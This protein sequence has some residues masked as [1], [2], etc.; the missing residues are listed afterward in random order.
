MSFAETQRIV[1]LAVLNNAAWC[2]SMWR[3]CGLQVEKPQGMVVCIGQ[4]PQFYPN[5]MTL[6]AD[7]DPVLQAQIIADL[8]KMA[9]GGQVSVKDSYARLDLAPLGFRKLFEAQWIHCPPGAKMPLQLDWRL[10]ETAADLQD[11]ESV[12]GGGSGVGSAVFPVALLADTSV[13]VFGG[14]QAGK[15]VAGAILSPTAPV[16][17]VSNVFGDYAEVTGLVASVFPGYGIVGYEHG[18]DLV[19]AMTAGFEPKGPLIVWCYL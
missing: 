11:W 5:A 1:G 7:G 2:V 17:G 16:V 19:T 4:P 12:W 9:E 18:V 15:L 8:V 13:G 14:W 6:D 3:A 10:V